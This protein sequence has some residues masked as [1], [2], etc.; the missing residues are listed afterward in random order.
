MNGISFAVSVGYAI[1]NTIA[2]VKNGDKVSLIMAIIWLI[3]L[4]VQYKY[5]KQI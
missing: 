2:F 5:F 4:F 3:W 1:I